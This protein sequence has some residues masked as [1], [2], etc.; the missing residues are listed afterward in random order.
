[1]LELIAKLRRSCHPKAPLY[2]TRSIVRGVLTSGETSVYDREPDPQRLG[3]ER[4]IAGRAETYGQLFDLD[5]ISSAYAEA[6]PDDIAQLH[7]AAL[8]EH[9]DIRVG[10]Y[11]SADLLLEHAPLPIQGLTLGHPV[12][13]T[14]MQ[15]WDA[16]ALIPVPTPRHAES[17]VAASKPTCRRPDIPVC[18]HE[19]RHAWIGEVDGALSD[20]LLKF[21]QVYYS[22]DFLIQGK[23]SSLDDLL[24]R[25]YL[26]AVTYRR[27]VATPILLRRKISAE[28]HQLICCLLRGMDKRD[29]EDEQ[30]P[31]RLQGPERLHAEARINQ[32]FLS[33]V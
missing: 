28:L 5:A 13:M 29:D 31:G 9:R 21:T 3:Y 8:Q 2:G 15:A 16:V 26:I 12:A 30:V 25:P 27:Y 17:P 20:E 32:A 22:T 11:A 33:S 14:L 6:L 18:E 10:T 19:G 24:G 7:I 23:P 4:I 1:M